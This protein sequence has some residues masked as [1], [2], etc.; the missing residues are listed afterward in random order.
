MPTVLIADDH[1]AV[2]SAVRARFE[3]CSEFAAGEA[4]NGADAIV[5]AQELKP[6]LII[7]D[8]SMPVLNGFEAAKLLR[9]AL[10]TVPIFLLT[11]QCTKAVE[12]AAVEAGI[13]AVFSK[14]ELGFPHGAGARHIG[15]E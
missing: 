13:R 12:K 1:A 3:G 14:E 6:D 10:P 7:L 2:R 5:K 4:E 8:L 11:A 15:T 9:E